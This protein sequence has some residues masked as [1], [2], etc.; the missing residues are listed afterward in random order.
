LSEIIILAERRAHKIPPAPKRRPINRV[1][2]ELNDGLWLLFKQGKS[3]ACVGRE[4]YFTE[5]ESV[6]AP[7]PEQ[8]DL[9]CRDAEG[10][11]CAM[12]ALCDEL[13][14]SEKPVSGVY[15]GN[16]WKDKRLVRPD[17]EESEAA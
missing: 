5:Y 15:G 10:V 12:K 3:P 7:T 14:R 4:K 17:I 16:V 9:M 2:K 8:A 1:R 6:D 11:E 13:A